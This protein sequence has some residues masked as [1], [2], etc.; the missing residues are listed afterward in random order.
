MLRWAQINFGEWSQ[1][2][3]TLQIVLQ[4]VFRTVCVLTLGGLWAEE[5]RIRHLSFGCPWA[6]GTDDKRHLRR[7]VLGQVAKG[8][9]KLNGSGT[10]Q[11]EV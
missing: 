2:L 6:R 7:T 5:E 9:A 8:R 4:C 1:H 11:E 3:I 10:V